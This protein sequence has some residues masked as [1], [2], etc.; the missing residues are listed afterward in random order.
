VNGRTKSKYSS[1]EKSE[2]LQQ[3]K[4]SRNLK[5]HITGLNITQERYCDKHTAIETDEHG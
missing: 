5:L 3:L 1:K 2:L 4:R